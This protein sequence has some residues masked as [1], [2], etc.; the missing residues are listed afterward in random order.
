MADA[1]AA[2]IAAKEHLVVEAGTGV[3]K[4]FAYLVPAILAATAPPLDE[5]KP[6]KPIRVVISTHTISLQEQL[7][8]KDLPLLNSVIPREFSAVL[9]KGRR[10]YVSLRRLHSAVQR[11]S[12]LFDKFE[13]VDQLRDLKTWSEQTSDGSLSDLP[14]QPLPQVWEEVAS[15]HGNC[16]GRR[17]PTYKQCHYYRA[18]RR[19]QHAQLMIV[20]HALFFSDLA[21]RRSGVSILPDYDIVVLD[22]AHTIDGVAADHMGIRLTSGQ[23]EFVLSRLYND[24]TQKGLLVH[25]EMRELQQEVDS[26]RV[27]ADAF[28]AELTDW[29]E[30]RAPSNGRIVQPPDVNNFLSGELQSLARAVKQ[31]GDAQNE[32]TERQ[33]FISAHDRLTVLAG[34]LNFW[35][36]QEM[37][38][39]V[40]WMES[41]K[42]RRG[43]PRLTLSAAPIDVGPALRDQLFNQVPTAILTSATLAVGK[44]DSFAFFCNRIGLVKTGTLQ[45]DSP[46]D[47]RRQAELVT[48]RGMPDPTRQ[49]EAYEEACVQ[50]IQRFVRETDGHA[51]VLFTS[52]EMMRRIGS[53]L[54]PWLRSQNLNLLNQADGTP[55]TRMIEL[56]K[57]DPRA[58][59]LG[60]DSFWQG[61]DVPGDA[62]QLVVITKLPFAVPDRP[63]L[64][65]R[66]Q[67]IRAGGGDPFREYQLPEAV[68]KL[69]QGFGRLIR[70]AADT[71]QVV[72]LDPRV[73]SKSYGR[74]F[75]ESLPN[76]RQVEIDFAALRT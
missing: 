32:E 27:A 66:L 24:R 74:V 67:A 49:H 9:V 30:S 55:R 17:C 39:A 23:I 46:F 31:A 6:T 38:S 8:R 34:E 25:H 40:Y 60:T 33:D 70:S 45:L 19:V 52:Y 53:R 18:R 15:D 43:L 71:G 54:F 36:R 4:S 72:I 48:L 37:D 28:F 21:L 57:K 12:S 2:A 73:Y 68:I 26:C 62:L 65:A 58:V 42:T 22:E 41:F 35:H 47:Y 16:L 75:L 64:E 63:L 76:C 14:Y 61:V 20:N 50:M 59:L 10:N 5:T 1:V 44:T 7:I 51:F 29:R 3:G 13:S 69:K 56:F 11:G